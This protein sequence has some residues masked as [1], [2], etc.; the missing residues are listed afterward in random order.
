MERGPQAT[1]VEWAEIDLYRFF[2]FAFAPPT[3]ERFT[4]LGQ[5]EF[6]AALARLWNHLSCTGAFPGLIPF[7][8]YAD[9]ESTYIAVFDVGLPE[10]PVPLV[11]SAHYKA[12]P[13]QETALENVSFYEV[14]GLKAD[15]SRYA[16]DHLVT[17]LE[18]LAAVRYARENTPDVENR[19]RLVRLERDFLVRHLLNWLPA[20]QKKLARERPPLFPLLM[21]LLLAALRRELDGL[22]PAS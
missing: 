12:Q 18:F 9:Y 7:Q 10:P 1:P 2:A 6:P 5:P 22:S 4:W 3:S 8:G 19:R 11:E 14:L 13:A 15:P 17:Q 20:A 16:P 21:T